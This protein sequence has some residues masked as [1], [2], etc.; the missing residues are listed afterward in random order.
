MLFFATSTSYTKAF[1]VKNRIVEILEKYDDVLNEK[2]AAS[3]R[4]NSAVED[5]INTELNEIGYRISQNPN[6]AVTPL[7]QIFSYPKFLIMPNSPIGGFFHTPKIA[8]M[9]I[10]YMGR[11][12]H[13]PRFTVT[14]IVIIPIGVYTG[15]LPTPRFFLWQNPNN[16]PIYAP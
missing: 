9:P 5:E 10:C 7:G 16:A 3:G 6:N 11:F 2:S 14:K 4:L 12:L 1:K 8:I 13:T 15:F